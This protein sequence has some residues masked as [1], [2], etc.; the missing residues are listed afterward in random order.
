MNLKHLTYQV[1][2]AALLFVAL[3]SP[4]GACAEEIYDSRRVIVRPAP[5]G[6]R[7]CPTCH[8]VHSGNRTRCLNSR[9]GILNPSDYV[10]DLMRRL[11]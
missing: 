1:A 11:R 10:A 9:R 3:L 4:V 2:T 5:R 7:Q 6:L 8:Q